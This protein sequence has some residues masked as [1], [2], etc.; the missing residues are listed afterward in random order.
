MNL[1]KGVIF[2][3]QKKK[4]LI[5]NNRGNVLPSTTPPQRPQVIHLITG[6]HF[7]FFSF[8]LSLQ[9]ISNGRQYLFAAGL[10]SY[11]ITRTPGTARGGMTWQKE[12]G[13][14]CQERLPM[15][16]QWNELCRYYRR[17]H[18]QSVI[19]RRDGRK[20]IFQMFFARGTTKNMGATL[21]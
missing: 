3:L 9:L 7:P 10:K 17:H 21:V 19:W 13:T 16:R 6:F 4:N 12:I 11:D 5:H 2:S 8:P 14:L 20:M 1:T 18:W 15:R